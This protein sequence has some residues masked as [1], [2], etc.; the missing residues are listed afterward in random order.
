M[1]TTFTERGLSGLGMALL[2]GIG[3]FAAFPE[4]GLP[5]ILLATIAAFIIGM[6]VGPFIVELIGII[7]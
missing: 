5:I 6:A 7:L 3:L 1:N 2:V 4:L